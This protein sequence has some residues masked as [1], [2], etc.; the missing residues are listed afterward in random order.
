MLAVTAL[1]TLP[2]GAS[3]AQARPKIRI[4]VL[5]D[6]SGTYRDTTGLT[7]VVCVQQAVQDFGDHG[8]DVEVLRADHQNKPDIGAT[9]AR[10]WIDRD[11]VDV[12]A[13]VPTSSVAL[14]VAEVCRQ[15]DRIHLNAS[16][17][18]VALTGEQCSPNTIVWSFDTYLMAASTG[19]AMVKAGGDSWYFIT[20]DYAFGHSL[21]G[22]TALKGKGAGGQGKG[23]TGTPF[24]PTTHFS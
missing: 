19:G 1:G 8:F 9:I 21:E 3:H 18:A 16:A 24:P 15:K 2:T 20:A 17:T 14:A 23:R 7:S 10:Q 4:G 11:G 12:I 5:N 6:Q 22:R 13:D